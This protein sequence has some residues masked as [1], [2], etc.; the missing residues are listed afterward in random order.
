MFAGSGRFTKAFRNRGWNTLPVDVATNDVVR[1]STNLNDHDRQHQLCA[2][3]RSAGAE[4]VHLGTPCTCFS[5]ARKFDGGPPPLRTS[6]HVLGLPHL[7]PAD[8]QKVELG[9]SFAELSARV[10]AQVQ[11]DQG[12]FSIENPAKSLFWFHPAIVRLKKQPGVWMVQF[13]M[14]TYGS[15]W[16]KPTALLTNCPRL[17]ALRSRCPRTRDHLH[18][19]LKGRVWDK[20][21]ARMVW[22]TSAAQVYPSQL[23]QR[24]VQLVESVPR[25]KIGVDTGEQDEPDRQ[26]TPSAVPA[27][28]L[29][30]SAERMQCT[31]DTGS[32]QRPGHAPLGAGATPAESRYYTHRAASVPS[33][34]KGNGTQGKLRCPVPDRVTPPGKRARYYTSEGARTTTC[35]GEG[36]YTPAPERSELQVPAVP[37]SLPIAEQQYTSG[38]PTRCGC[39]LYTSDAADE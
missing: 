37:P 10:A 39:L 12:F 33:S 4:F 36:D 35:A 29:P 17:R 15:T 11:Q 22:R 31:Q 34:V 13:D 21:Q 18:R 23:C 19:P 20:H 16:Q 26:H 24:I 6:S 25:G 28:G 30:C 5:R 9:N 14:C 38:I 32:T 27:R 8:R 2:E 7:K 3:L 1:T